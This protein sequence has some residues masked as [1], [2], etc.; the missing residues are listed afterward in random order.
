[1][2]LVLLLLQKY[3]TMPRPNQAAISDGCKQS[4]YQEAGHYLRST[5]RGVIIVKALMGAV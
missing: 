4:E 2:V 3:I 1:M 5:A